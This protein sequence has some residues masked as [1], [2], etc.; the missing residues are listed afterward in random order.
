[1]TKTTPTAPSGADSARES[2]GLRFEVSS[3]VRGGTISEGTAGEENITVFA[4]GD[5]AAGT[6][7]TA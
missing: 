1:M 5:G 4:A 7:K 2:I 3:A 6:S